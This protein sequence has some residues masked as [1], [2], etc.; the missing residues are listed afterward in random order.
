MTLKFSSI[1]YD[2]IKYLL[3]FLEKF[4]T[5]FKFNFTPSFHQITTK[6]KIVNVHNVQYTLAHTCA[7]HF[8]TNNYFKTSK[9]EGSDLLKGI[10]K[11]K[12]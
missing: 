4:S 2:F 7:V 9:Q 8:H 11:G 10:F 5:D 1:P 3:L 12:L 6:Y